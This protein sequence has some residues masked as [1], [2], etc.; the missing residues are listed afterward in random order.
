MDL[1]RDMEMYVKAYKS[2]ESTLDELAEK[3]TDVRGRADEIYADRSSLQ[4]ELQQ[5]E[6]SVAALRG[7]REDLKLEHAEASFSN[8]QKELERISQERTNIEQSINRHHKD[9]RAVRSKLDSLS[10]EELEL[11]AAKIYVEV[12]QA[13]TGVPVVFGELHFATNL[14]RN[15]LN[16]RADT[17]KS[18]L[19]AYSDEVRKQ[20]DSDFREQQK[21]EEARRAAAEAQRIADEKKARQTVRAVNDQDSGYLLGYDVYEEGQKI[22]FKPIKK[23]PIAQ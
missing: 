2:A 1:I 6:R 9:I 23:V 14:A 3:A 16:S 12:E 19:P 22:A 17:I 7:Q 21:R 15:E 8:D 11:E 13:I 4:E 18:S 20:V 10:A 5:H